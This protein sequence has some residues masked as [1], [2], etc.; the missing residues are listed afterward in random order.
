M[1]WAIELLIFNMEHSIH[2]IA[3]SPG[4]AVRP[5]TTEDTSS[6]YYQRRIALYMLPLSVSCRYLMY[7][8]F[9][10]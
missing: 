6:Y 8:C 1:K 4:G 10:T 7:L 2:S 5:R 3:I 9:T